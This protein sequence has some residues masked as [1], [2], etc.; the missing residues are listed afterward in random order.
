M[1]YIKKADK[2]Q[3]ELLD[4]YLNEIGLPNKWKDF[5]QEEKR[6]E[7]L[8][9]KNKGKCKCL[10]CSNEFESTKKINEYE[11]C[12]KCN[13][14]LLIKSSLLKN[15]CKK[16]DLTLIQKYNKEYVFRT[17]ELFTNYNHNKISFTLTEYMRILKSKSL[18]TINFYI[19]NNFKN[20]MGYLYIDHCERTKTWRPYE[21][22]Y[23]IAEYSRYYYYNFKEL[24]YNINRYSMIWEL[25]KNVDILNFHQV[26]YDCLLLKKNTVELLTKSKLY[27]LANNCEKYRKKGTFEEIFGVDRSYLNFMIENDITPDELNIL[28]KIKIKDINLIRYLEG[29]NYQLD[30]LLQYCKPLDLYK[31]HLKHSNVHEYLD[32]IRFAKELRYDISNKSILYPKNLKEQHNKLQNLIETNKNKAITKKIK[33][34]Y[35]KNKKNIYQNKKYIIFPASSV[36]ELIEESAQQNN[37]VKTYAERY[38]KGQCDIYFM[39]LLNDQK[40]SLVTVEIKDNKVVQQRTK[41]NNDTTPEQKRFLKLWEK[42]ILRGEL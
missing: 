28:A 17:F 34:R 37:C 5:V 1:G 35:N 4:E 13:T 36:D 10:Y 15:Y 2:Q 38:S 16:K 40:K 25:A 9:I 21:Y 7:Y 6:K 32:Y 33:L 41:N 14:K 3:I 30:S 19:S 8:I 42:K 29:F 23:G 24:F 18:T 22:R 27:N 39:R 26:A 11:T 20:N 31:Y 12:P